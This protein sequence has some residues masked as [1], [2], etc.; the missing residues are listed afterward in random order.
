MAD[1]A[2]G[3]DE[4]AVA[5]AAPSVLL[6]DPAG[7]MHADGVQGWYVDDVRLLRRLE[8]HV[9]PA[10]SATVRLRP[11]A[12]ARRPHHHD[13]GH[14]RAAP[15][16]STSGLAVAADL[17]PV[18]VVRQQQETADL[19]PRIGADG[20]VLVRRGHAAAPWS[21]TPP[22]A[23]YDGLSWQL[24]VGPDA[25]ARVELRF[26]AHGSPQFA[27]GGTPPWRTDV[28]VPAG[29]PRWS[30]LVEQGL[31]DLAGLLLRDGRRRV[32]GGRGAVVPH[33]VRPRRALDGA[34]DDAPRHRARP[35]H[36]ARARPA[37]GRPRRPG[38]RGAARQDPARGP[39]GH[40]APGRHGAAARL[41]RHGRRHPAVRVHAGRRVAAGADRDEVAALLPAVRRCLAL[42]D[43]A[44]P[45]VR[46]AAVRRLLG[47]RAGQPGVEGQR[48][49]GPVRRRRP[50]RGADRALR[51]AGLRLRG[52]GPGRR[53]AGGLRRAAGRRAGGVGGLAAPPLPG[54]VLGR[55]PRGRARG[56]RAGRR[57]RPAGAVASNMGHLLG[58]GLLDA[59]QARRVA[60][61]LAGPTMSSGYGLRTLALDSPAYDRLSYHC[62][63]VW[64]HDTAIVVR[65]L[66]A[67]GF[68]AEAAAAGA[69]ARRGVRDVRR[70]AA[71]ALLRRRAGARRARPGGVPLGLPAAGVGRGRPAGLPGRAAGHA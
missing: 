65:G 4:L 8:A 59:A 28:P 68:R 41:L 25:P 20:L 49:R 10:G 60:T 53:A 33:D 58:T 56:D 26:T 17:A 32:R 6:T 21:A 69:G 52:G 12:R 48:R 5:V 7:P 35:V 29:D 22:P 42:G 44:V 61:V 30:R 3:L 14:R 34:P 67:E 62:G 24:T 54:G 66:V 31:A 64:P 19:P 39:L 37:P 45:G 13:R 47:P 27:A 16:R 70:P 57:G 15:P 50:G 46:L 71:R 40:R 63:S 1:I 11:R 43:G 23:S 18:A 36:A 55:H 51:G 2:P 9:S 38:H